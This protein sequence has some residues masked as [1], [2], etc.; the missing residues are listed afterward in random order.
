MRVLIFP[1]SAAQFQRDPPPREL[2][3]FSSHFLFSTPLF[4]PRCL[5]FF[6]TFICFVRILPVGRIFLSGSRANQKR[7]EEKRTKGRPT[8]RRRAALNM[9]FLILFVGCHGQ[10]SQEGAYAIYM[11]CCLGWEVDNVLFFHVGFERESK[12]TKEFS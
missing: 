9:V 5:A 7:K 8:L 3:L 4:H 2:S 11:E 6:H 10:I 12:P 1:I